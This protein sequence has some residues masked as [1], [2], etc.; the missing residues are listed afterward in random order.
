MKLSQLLAR[1]DHGQHVEIRNDDG[2]LFRGI[3]NDI[4]LDIAMHHHVD[5]FRAVTSVGGIGY[6][7]IVVY[8]D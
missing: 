1:Y 3:C 7:Y 8:V 2:V 4:P 6:P 5:S